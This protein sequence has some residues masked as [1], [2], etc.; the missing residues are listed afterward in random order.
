MRFLV[1]AAL[2]AASCAR[3]LPIARQ[4]WMLEEVASR[5]HSFFDEKHDPDPAHDVGVMR[6]RFGL[7]AIAQAGA[8]FEIDLLERGGPQAIRA[9]LVTHALADEQAAACLSGS[10]MEGCWPLALDAVEREPLERG[11]ALAR[12]TAHAAP[13]AGG[14][15][16][17]VE[18]PVDAPARLPRAVWLR[19]ADPA[20]LAEVQVAQLSDLH[21]GKGG[22][23]LQSEIRQHLER[24]IADLNEL[25][26][27]VVIIT[28]DV[29]QDGNNQKLPAEALKLLETVEAPILAILGN[30]DHGFDS[31]AFS[32]KRYGTGWESFARAFHAYLHFQVTIGGWDFIGFDSGPS[33][34]SPLVLTRGLLPETVAEL[35]ADV[36]R[37]FEAHHRGVL[38]F[39]HAPS[40]ALYNGSKPTDKRGVVGK[41]LYGGTAFERV[42]LDAAARGQR[43]LHLAGHTHW[44]D[45]FESKIDPKRGLEF[46]RWDHARLGAAPQEVV[47]KACLITTQS[48]SHTTYPRKD[49]GKGYGFAWLTLGDQDPVL[50][51]HRYAT[52]P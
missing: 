52:L 30:H 19:D 33:E 21:V 34:F 10:L 17:Y 50:N 13:P 35:H 23:K 9:A 8:A 2:G 36:E 41:M 29:F 5:Y 46:V 1:L 27:D 15:D 38:L 42:L 6:P 22:T 25:R 45:V 3:P 49:N 44:N 12:V 43:V 37:S 4:D 51:F 7:P 18:S 48:C 11:V 28:G 31:E 32:A 47:G 20:A 16:L 24:V 14:Y 39:S 40:R 26:P